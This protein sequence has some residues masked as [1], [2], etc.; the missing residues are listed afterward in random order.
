MTYSIKILSAQPVR[1]SLTVCGVALCMILMLFLLGIYRGVADGS[2][3]YIRENKAD[4]W[5]L[6][7]NTTNILRGTSFLSS[8]QGRVIKKYNDVQTVS[9]VLLL[10]TNIKNGK[11]NLTIFLAGYD[12]SLK[13]GGPPK[14]I[15][16]RNVKED[17]EIVLDR[18][19]A[20]K[21]NFNVGDKVRLQDDSLTVVGISSGTNAFV[22]QYAF[23]TLN[24]A[25]S[26]SGIPGL[27]TCFLIKLNDAGNAVKASCDIQGRLKGIS[28]YPYREFLQ[29]NIK[30]MES[31]FLPILYAIAFLGAVVLT[32]VL[33][34]ILSINILEKKKDFA[35]LKMLGAPKFFLPAIV[36]QQAV[37]ICI[38]SGLVSAAA[39][40]PLAELIEK[41]SPEVCTKTTVSQIAAVQ[42]AGIIMGLISSSVSIR[43]IRKIYPLE[44]FYDK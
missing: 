25:Q 1:L 4:L 14:I 6:Q 33:S 39:F 8:S 21:N 41:I 28:V 11:D 40:F 27:V 16:G 20:V 35:V 37:L 2:V 34:L 9:P 5:I 17:D 38:F 22:I 42:C 24:E 31:G 43:R 36:V 29:N 12:P 7:N 32:A 26:L 23:T 13:L 19:F 30:E 18:S 15:N 10:L 3:D 44:V